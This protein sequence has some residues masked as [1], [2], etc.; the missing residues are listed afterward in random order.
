MDILAR[1]LCL[2]SP[3]TLAS[4]AYV[5]S[6]PTYLCASVASAKERVSDAKERTERAT[7][8]SEQ[9]ERALEA[10]MVRVTGWGGTYT[11]SHGGSISGAVRALFTL[12]SLP[13]PS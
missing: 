5:R 12:F 11:V 8:K 2:C 9:R 1:S 4:T 10:G 13:P 7:R 3:G 6:F